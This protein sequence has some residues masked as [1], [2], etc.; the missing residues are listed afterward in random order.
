LRSTVESLWSK[1]QQLEKEF[2]VIT[3]S[4]EQLRANLESI[5]A[6]EHY[7][8][9]ITRVTENGSL[10]VETAAPGGFRV[11][12]AVHPDIDP[13]QLAVGRRG[14]LSRERNCLLHLE[15]FETDWPDVGLFEDYIDGG[16]RILLRH[17]DELVAV[18]Q[19]RPIGRYGPEERRPYR[20]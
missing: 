19:T 18:S 20:L 11:Q 16:R 8:V 9:V 13:S 15:E 6:P 10:R 7:P 2:R 17:Q 3:A 5:C 4:Q 12:V 1:N 14:F